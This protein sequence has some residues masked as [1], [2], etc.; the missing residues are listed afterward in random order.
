MRITDLELFDRHLELSIPEMKKARSLFLEGKEDEAVSTFVKYFKSTLRDDIIFS[1]RP[2]PLTDGCPVG[3][4][5][6]G[7]AD[8]IV[9]GH[10]Y[11]IGFLHKYDNK[12]RMGLQSHL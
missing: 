6:K 5:M 2:Q 8:L 10:M 11:A 9:D 3:Y 7:Y 12:S 1:F 4:D